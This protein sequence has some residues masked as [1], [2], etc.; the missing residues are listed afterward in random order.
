MQP[1]FFH[2][3]SYLIKLL[4]KI[5]L[6]KYFLLTIMYINNLII[7]IFKIYNYIFNSLYF[8]IEIIK[9]RGEKK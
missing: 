6:N 9:L 1:F 7:N 8:N 2:I 5:T 3:L 4:V